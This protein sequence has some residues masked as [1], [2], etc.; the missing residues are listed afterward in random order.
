M[1]IIL[2][3]FSQVKC[4]NLWELLGTKDWIAHEHGKYKMGKNNTD[5]YMGIY[6]S[7][8][9]FPFSCKSKLTQTP[10]MKAKLTWD[11]F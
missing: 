9:P 4:M 1:Q 3:Y 2:K 11:R 5:I 6:I 7:I 8:Y 10:G